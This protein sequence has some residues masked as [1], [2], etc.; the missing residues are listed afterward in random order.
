MCRQEHDR[1]ELARLLRVSFFDLDTEVEAFYHESIPRLQARFVN[2]SNY[3]GKACRVLKHIFA[4]P[5]ATECVVALP[6]SGLRPPFWNVIK[7]SRSIVIVVQA[8]PVNI[9]ARIVFFDDDS[10]PMDRRLT[11]E[12]RKHYF[13]EI[14]KDIRYFARSYS[15]ADAAVGING[16]CPLEAAKKIKAVIESVDRETGKS[17][18]ETRLEAVLASHARGHVAIG[19]LLPTRDGQFVFRAFRFAP[20]GLS[21]VGPCSRPSSHA[22]PS[23]GLS[24]GQADPIVVA[25]DQS[26]SGALRWTT[27]LINAVTAVSP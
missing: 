18:K 2:I 19:A 1:A 3:R 11:T 10:R 21:G 27:N 26:G 9:L 22:R 5:E 15:K 25:L 12:E 8:D 23:L 16:L 7:A 6:P 13:D 24:V 4:Q 20:L 17:H 14:K